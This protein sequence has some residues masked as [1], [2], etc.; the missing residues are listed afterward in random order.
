MIR[1][2]LILLSCLLLAFCSFKKEEHPSVDYVNKYRDF[3]IAEMHRSGV[4]ASIKLGQ[5][6]I[7]TANGK[8]K[9]ALIANNHFGIKCK[10]YWTGKTYYSKD[11]DRDEKGRLIDSCFR[12]YD[13]AFDSFIDHS[14]FLKHTPHYSPL[15]K[16]S[17]TD[18]KAWAHT[19]KSCGYATHPRYAEMLIKKIEQLEL[20]KLDVVD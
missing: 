1:T 8:S 9:L 2:R 10:S 3:A 12:S 14:N 18:Y 4:P 16:L 19:L 11:D 5:A 15:F 20:Y 13:Q 17:K 7:E 6:L